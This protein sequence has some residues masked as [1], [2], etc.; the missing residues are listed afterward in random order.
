MVNELSDF[1]HDSPALSRCITFKGTIWV[2][3]KYV[4]KHVNI[5]CVAGGISGCICCHL[6][7]LTPNTINVD[8]YF[9]M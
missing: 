1:Y 5:Y 4:N 2:P 7:N 9:K 8:A 6:V 3:I